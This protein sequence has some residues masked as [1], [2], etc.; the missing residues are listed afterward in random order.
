MQEYVIETF[1]R[2][3]ELIEQYDARTVVYRGI[4][5]LEYPLIP[6]IGRVTPPDSVG[7]RERNEQEIL[8]LFKERAFQY[9]D[10]LLRRPEGLS[11][12]EMAKVL[13]KLP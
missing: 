1:P 4:K 8:R 13:A 9:L 3:H 7:S 10:F 6:K 2:F 5:S 12:D 11:I